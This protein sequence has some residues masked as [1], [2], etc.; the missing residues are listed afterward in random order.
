MRVI[1]ATTE[2][3]RT[4]DTRAENFINAYADLGYSEE[5]SETL[6]AERLEQDDAALF[7]VPACTNFSTAKET[8]WL[9][10]AASMLCCGDLG[11]AEAL[12]LIEMVRK[13]LQ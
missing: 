3:N 4:I 9:L 10:E 11:N 2:V 7:T 8:V 13:S 12:R 5:D 6:G 1:T